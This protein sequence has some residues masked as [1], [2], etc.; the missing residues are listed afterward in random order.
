[1]RDSSTSRG[2][3]A[4]RRRDGNSKADLFPSFTSAISHPP[5]YYLPPSSLSSK[6]SLELEPKSSFCEVSSSLSSDSLRRA[7]AS[8]P[9]PPP[10]SSLSQWKGRA[11][12]HT[13]FIPPSDKA[14]SSPISIKSRIW[15]Y[16]SPTPSFAPIASYLSFYAS[17]GGDGKNGKW[18]CRV[19][20]EDVIPQEGDFYGGWKTKDVT[21][22]KKGMKGG[23]SSWKVFR[24]PVVPVGLQAS[25]RIELTLRLFFLILFQGLG[26][27]AGDAASSSATGILASK[28]ALFVFLLLTSFYSPRF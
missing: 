18:V 23:E 7:H 6:V 22:G 26:P 12:Y 24:F 9:S 2:Q 8:F 25:L 17:D 4:D 19:D 21:G 27:G 16:E 5:T 15:S 28:V 11:S 10:S 1:M 14:S 20:G 13:L 3:G